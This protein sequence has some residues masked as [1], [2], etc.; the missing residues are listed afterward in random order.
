MPFDTDAAPPNR[1]LAIN[2]TAPSDAAAP[3]S[4]STA[5]AGPIN[6]GVPPSPPAIAPPPGPLVSMAPPVGS[7]RLGLR[8][9]MLSDSA[10][11]GEEGKGEEGLGALRGFLKEVP[12]PTA[13]TTP[14]LHPLGRTP[15][16][17][18]CT[19][20]APPLQPLAPTLP[21]PRARHRSLHRLCATS[22]PPLHHL[23]TAS[24]PPL[25]HLCTVSAPQGNP[26]IVQVCALH[27]C[28][29]TTHAPP[30]HRPCTASAPLLHRS[31]TAVQ[32]SLQNKLTE[33]RS[34]YAS[35]PDELSG[36]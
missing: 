25:H 2:A 33:L 21:A 23:C 19:S 6:G 14:R 20:L 29:R 16:H 10:S 34:T 8:V 30:V 4:P 5:R 31:C 18:P 11:T 9:L 1:A 22:A 36:R 13:S 3:L 27:A 12:P 32:M 24:A 15:R 7:G 17:P 28:V 26:I 35:M